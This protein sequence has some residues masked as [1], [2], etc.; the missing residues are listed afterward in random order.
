MVAI[1]PAIPLM[2]PY[3]ASSR[4]ISLNKKGLRILSKKDSPRRK[5]T[6]NASA[7]PT[8]GC[9]RKLAQAM[10]KLDE[11]PSNR[12][13]RPGKSAKPESSTTRSTS[14][15]HPSSDIFSRRGAAS[16]TSFRSPT[17]RG[18]TIS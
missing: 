1:P 7:R 4:P 12:R 17:S 8:L 18:T 13:R 9:S 16:K 11:L 5:S 14:P 3:M 10:A 15:I 6:I 2:L